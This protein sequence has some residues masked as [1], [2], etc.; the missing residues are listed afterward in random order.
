MF[1]DS[2]PVMDKAW[3]KKSGLGWIGKNGNLINKKKGSFFFLATLI[4]DLVLAPDLPYHQDYCGSCTRCI[5]CQ[6]PP[7]IP[8]A[9]PKAVMWGHSPWVALV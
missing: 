6:V 8:F 7:S 9:T 2:A 5:A 4:T 3:A 1:V